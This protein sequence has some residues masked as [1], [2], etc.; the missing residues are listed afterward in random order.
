MCYSIIVCC[1]ILLQ[2]VSLIMELSCK[3]E[4][5]AVLFYLSPISLRLYRHV[6]QF[7]SFA[8]IPKHVH[9]SFVLCNMY[10]CPMNHNSSPVTNFSQFQNAF[11]VKQKLLNKTN[12]WE[13]TN[14]NSFTSKTKMLNLSF[15][16]SL[17]LFKSFSVMANFMYFLWHWWL[18]YI[19][20]KIRI[21]TNLY[22]IYSFNL[23]FLGPEHFFLAL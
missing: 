14:K 3:L 21:K 6:W 23:H 18:R 5:L 4:I 19:Q 7:F 15:F 2:I 17:K 10:L 22:Q 1:A 12:Q 8:W 9:W 16:M 20:S 11:L 13:Q